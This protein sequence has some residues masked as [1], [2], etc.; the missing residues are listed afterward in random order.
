MALDPLDR[1]VAILAD[2]AA[3]AGLFDEALD[4]EPATPPRSEASPPK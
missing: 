1:I 4:D 2:A 3:R